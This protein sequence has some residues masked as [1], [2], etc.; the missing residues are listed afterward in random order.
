MDRKVMVLTISM[1][2]GVCSAACL[3][4]G[5]DNEWIDFGL[6]VGLRAYPMESMCTLLVFERDG[7]GRHN[8]RVASRNNVF[9][10]QW[11]DHL[12]SCT[13]K[14]SPQEMTN[15]LNRVGTRVNQSTR[16]LI[17]TNSERDHTE[18]NC[19]V[20]YSSAFGGHRP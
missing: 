10:N 18:V 5:A 11:I 15:P 6:L 20:E 19:I 1:H 2:C 17:H 7:E 12:W 13:G 14:R 9:N 16:H 3:S 4:I 8:N